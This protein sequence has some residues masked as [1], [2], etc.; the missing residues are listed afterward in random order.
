MRY[1]IIFSIYSNGDDHFFARTILKGLQKNAN[2]SIGFSSNDSEQQ[3]SRTQTR[4]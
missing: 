4:N 3:N 1:V 2:H